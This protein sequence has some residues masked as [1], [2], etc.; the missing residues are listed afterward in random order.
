[1][2]ISWALLSEGIGDAVM[3]ETG[4]TLWARNITL[5]EETDPSSLLQMKEWTNKQA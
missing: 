1:M 4:E 5:V 3:I 2:S